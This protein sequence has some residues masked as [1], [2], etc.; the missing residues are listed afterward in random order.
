MNQMVSTRYRNNKTESSSCTEK[1]VG[2]YTYGKAET[3]CPYKPS[4]LPPCVV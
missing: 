3:C 4:L 1:E 2:F